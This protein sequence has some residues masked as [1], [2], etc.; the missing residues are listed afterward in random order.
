MS[1]HVHFVHRG[2]VYLALPAWS[3]DEPPVGY[4]RVDQQQAVQI[5]AAWSHDSS[6]HAKF[7]GLGRVQLLRRQRPS[8]ASTRVIDREPN[9]V[10][11]E[12]ESIGEEEEHWIEIVLIGEDDEGIAGVVCEVT[13]P[14]G[15]RVRRT[16]D[17]F[18]FVRIEG[19]ADP[20]DCLVTFPDLDGDAWVDA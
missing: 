15:Q 9:Y 2:D 11:P 13:L 17:R 4:E 10:S 19:L 12:L 6:A 1:E 8:L 14:S 7:G 16:T 20:R 3:Q 18:G 5:L